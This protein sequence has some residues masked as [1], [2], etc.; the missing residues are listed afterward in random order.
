MRMT[1]AVPAEFHVFGIPQSKRPSCLIQCDVVE[2]VRMVSPPRRQ[3]YS[4]RRRM[5]PTQVTYSAFVRLPPWVTPPERWS[6]LL[7]GE[8]QLTV[9]V[10]LN[11]RVEIPPFPVGKDRIVIEQETA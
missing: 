9:S 2:L 4:R 1:F 8:V 5:E 6:R 11:R 10:A 3:W 7:S